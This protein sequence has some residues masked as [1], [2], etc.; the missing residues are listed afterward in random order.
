MS[1]IIKHIKENCKGCTLEEG[2]IMAKSKGFI[3]DRDEWFAFIWDY[4]KESRTLFPKDRHN[5]RLAREHTIE[6]L[7]ITYKTFSNARGRM[8]GSR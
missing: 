1:Y 2:L 4:Y 8:K 7:G 3:H 5:R 6:M